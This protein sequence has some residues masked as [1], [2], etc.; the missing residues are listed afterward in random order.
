M[1]GIAGAKVHLGD[2]DPSEQQHNLALPIGTVE[3][4]GC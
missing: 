3:L 2:D 4:A 1:S